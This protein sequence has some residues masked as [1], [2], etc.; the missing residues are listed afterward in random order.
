MNADHGENQGQYN[1]SVKAF[2]YSRFLIR[3]HQRRFLAKSSTQGYSCGVNWSAQAND[4]E[5]G[6]SAVDNHRLHALS[7]GHEAF[8]FTSLG[9]KSNIV[10]NG[11]SSH[12]ESRY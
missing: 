7:I 11:R 1:N 8:S 5:P 6:T 2:D 4:L 12:L 10:D 3:V 9:A